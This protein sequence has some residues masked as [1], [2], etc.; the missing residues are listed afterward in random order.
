VKNN[1]HF[2]QVLTSVPLADTFITS[3]LFH[4]FRDAKYIHIFVSYHLNAGQNRERKGVNI[5]FRNVPWY[6]QLEEILIN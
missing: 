4:L 2:L 3:S 5:L 1:F 6:K